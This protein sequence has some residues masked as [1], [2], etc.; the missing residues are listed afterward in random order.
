MAGFLL[1]LIGGTATLS[2]GASLLHKGYKAATGKYG[3]AV[4]QDVQRKF[5][6]YKTQATKAWK[7]PNYSLFRRGDKSTLYY[8]KYKPQL[9]YDKPMPGGGVMKGS[10]LPY[11]PG[12]NVHKSRKM[13][14]VN[15]RRKEIAASGGRWSKESVAVGKVGLYGTGGLLAFGGEDTE[16]KVQDPGYDGVKG[17]KDNVIKNN[18]HKLDSA[19][20][21]ET[22]ARVETPEYNSQISG[23]SSTEQIVIPS[24][25]GRTNVKVIPK[26]MNKQA[27]SQYFVGR[28]APNEAYRQ[29]QSA[30]L[31]RY[32]P[33]NLQAK[34]QKLR[35]A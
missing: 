2:R 22:P 34:R 6:A 21:T 32:N 28:D 17:G 25:D 15:E 31:K 14:M 3:K 19:N 12:I 8:N 33:Q 9:T 30:S 35:R 13:A 5:K 26:K 23:D 7:D 29:V 16:T 24:M 4:V 20:N 27:Y 1:P 18:E 11:N 10:G